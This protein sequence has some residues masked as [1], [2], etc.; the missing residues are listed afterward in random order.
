[1]Y[2]IDAYNYGS[3]DVPMP[4]NLFIIF[5]Q[6]KSPPFWASFSNQAGTNFSMISLSS[7]MFPPFAMFWPAGYHFSAYKQ[8]QFFF[9]ISKPKE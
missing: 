3:C 1:M 6:P 4:W 5:I 8:G 7:T 2:Y 9:L